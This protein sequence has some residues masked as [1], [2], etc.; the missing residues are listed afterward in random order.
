[1]NIE[2]WAF[3]TQTEDNMD[4]FIV[5]EGGKYG[6]ITLPKRE[7]DD[8]SDSPTFDELEEQADS[9]NTPGREDD[10]ASVSLTVEELKEQ[11][12]SFI[13][14]IQWDEIRANICL[15]P[16]EDYSDDDEGYKRYLE[17]NRISCNYYV[18]KDGFWGILDE[19]GCVIQEPQYEEALVVRSLI[20]EG[21]KVFMKRPSSDFL[22]VSGCVLVRKGA[23]WGMLRGQGRMILPIVY[24]SID[25]DEYFMASENVYIVRKD[26]LCGVVD[27]SGK[28]LI[29]I[30]YPSLKGRGLNYMWNS[31]VFR[32]DGEAG[33]GYVRLG[34]AKCL[35]APE[36][37]RVSFDR[38]Y[39]AP[40]D[41]PWGYIFTVWK[42]GHCGLIT[43]EQGMIIPPVWDEIVAQRIRY[44][45]DPLSYSVRRGNHWGCC[46]ADGKLIC[47]A[48]WDEVKI[49]I[50]GVACV[51]KDGLWGVIN[52]DGQ[53]CVPTEW[54]DIGGFGVEVA[55]DNALANTNMGVLMGMWN[56]ERIL[57]PDWLSWVK[58]DGLW[59]LIRKDGSVAIEP[60]WETCDA[61]VALKYA[62]KK[63][64][65]SLKHIFPE[66]EDLEKAS[67]FKNE[68]W[69]SET[70]IRP[71]DIIADDT[72]DDPDFWDS[73]DDLVLDDLEDFPDPDEN[74]QEEGE[75]DPVPK[76]DDVED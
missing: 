3:T 16:D 76:N 63:A 59:G 27:Q 67:S 64:S 58:K 56:T 74:D 51:R 71:I 7:D 47:D 11:G 35:V 62:A 10:D 30:V 41:E 20:S 55:A 23:K 26:G 50:N 9:S 57:L 39:L 34:D 37:E 17:V 61:A 22:Y 21:L 68:T 18:L 25:V 14:P 32:I 38:F 24:D 40:D 44:T 12:G 65:I 1:M 70:D 48:V 2:N 5:S 53:L 8:A 46:D 6:L 28:I 73:L 45:S 36:W 66:D 33:T 19:A 15:D 4:I 60:M 42:N 69:S 43:D 13:T 54:D 29:P 75:D 72:P 49:L 52:A 31:S